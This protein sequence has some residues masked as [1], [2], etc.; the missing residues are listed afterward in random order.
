M[1]LMKNQDLTGQLDEN[2]TIII[3]SQWFQFLL[4]FTFHGRTSKILLCNNFFMTLNI[5]SKRRRRHVYI[6]ENKGIL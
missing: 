1:N 6:F 2:Q 4:L 3:L 5:F